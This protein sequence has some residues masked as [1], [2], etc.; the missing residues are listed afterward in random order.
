MATPIGFDPTYA[1]A[2]IGSLTL[3]AIYSD[4][5]KIYRCVKT[6]DLNATN[7]MVGEMAFASSW[8]L[9][10]DRAGG[11]SLGRIP[12][13]VFV[14]SVTAGYYCLVLIDGLHAA[15]KDAAGALNAVGA[16][17]RTHATVDGDAA[18]ATADG[19]GTADAE[20]FLGIVTVVSA[21]GVAGVKV[22]IG[23]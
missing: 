2:T 9:T 11:S 4:G 8:V 20:I 14:G 17:V 10:V 22:H 3:G 1:A 19:S 23:S 5:P 7:G 15:V 6:I 13:G 12:G 16:R 21:G 18:K